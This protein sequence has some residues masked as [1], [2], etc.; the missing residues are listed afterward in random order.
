MKKF[1][2]YLM[3]DVTNSSRTVGNLSNVLNIEPEGFLQMMTNN[4]YDRR[5]SNSWVIE[6]CQEKFQKHLPT[7]EIVVASVNVERASIQKFDQENRQL[8][9]ISDQE[10]LDCSADTL[11]ASKVIV[12]LEARNLYDD[13]R[14]SMAINLS[15]DGEE[16]AFGNT[17]DICTNFTILNAD[18]RFSSHPRHRDRSKRF[19]TIQDLMN[20]IDKIFPRI[21]ENLE[22]DLNFIDE[23]KKIT[24]HRS[25]WHTLVGELFSRIHYVNRQRLAKNIAA[26]PVEMKTLPITASILANISAESI[27]PSHPEYEWEGDYINKWNLINFGTEIIKL[28]SGAP[29]ASW[30][31]TTENWGK[32]IIERD[33]SA[34]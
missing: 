3:S 18:R 24:V 9:L 31:E 28:E 13:Y 1:A 17:V 25:E 19:M 23:L 8:L 10:L 33:F 4:G 5:F 11:I 22:S 29:P 26:I 2:D 14:P 16:I 21:E 34:N 30:M 6:A 32:L 27:S 12:K 20:E 7:S 15:P